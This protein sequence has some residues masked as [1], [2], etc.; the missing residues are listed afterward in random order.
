MPD[1]DYLKNRDKYKILTSRNYLSARSKRLDAVL[2]AIDT[3]ILQPST[4]TLDTVDSTLKEWE[5]KDPKEFKDRGLPWKLKMSTEI[6]QARLEALTAR[7]EVTIPVIEPHS[8]PVYDPAS[9]NRD[10][11]RTST[12][13]YAYACDSQ[14][15][16]FV[17]EKPQPGAYGKEKLKT[18]LKGYRDEK[19]K[20]SRRKKDKLQFGDAA[21]AR[22]EAA[23]RLAIMRDA[24]TQGLSKRLIPII[25][26][27]GEPVANITGHYL[28]ALVIAPGH[29]IPVSD[30]EEY[31]RDYHWY[32]QDRDGTWSH[33]PGHSYATNKDG[34]GNVIYDPRTC[35]MQGSIEDSS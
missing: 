21:P 20:K 22:T 10:P 29:Q 26:R 16:H 1:L 32:R 12:N 14:G 35:D 27:P 19:G 28:I 13:C 8:H 34:S 23:V 2:K 15:G 6:Q 30:D 31:I 3:F 11:Y 18:G 9:W 4:T 25:R 5:Q 7:G 24:Q 17:G 33:K